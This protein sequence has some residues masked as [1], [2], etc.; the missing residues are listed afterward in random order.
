MC[1]DQVI[2]LFPRMRPNPW[3]NYA[4]VSLQTWR[5]HSF[6]FLRALFVLIDDKHWANTQWE[7][8]DQEHAVLTRDRPGAMWGRLSMASSCFLSQWHE[9][10]RTLAVSSRFPQSPYFLVYKALPRSFSAGGTFA[11]R[12]Q[13]AMSV[14]TVEGRECSC[15]LVGGGE[16]CC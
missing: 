13:L 14:V 6:P 8:W 12:R 11:F 3:S 15:R 5:G 10:L 1:Q 9:C 4:V 7:P 2:S 16:G